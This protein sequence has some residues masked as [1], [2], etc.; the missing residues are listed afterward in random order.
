MLELF[1]DIHLQKGRN[2]D[3]SAGYKLKNLYFGCT[4]ISKISIEKKTQKQSRCNLDDLV[5][6]SRFNQIVKILLIT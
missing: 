1:G 2:N 3:D 6:N 5:S 4:Y